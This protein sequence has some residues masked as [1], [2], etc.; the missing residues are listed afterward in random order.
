MSQVIA[1][2]V[3]DCEEHPVPYMTVFVPPISLHY[4]VN[5]CSVNIVRVLS[6]ALDVRVL[7]S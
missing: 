6:S 2:A 3:E 7:S 1:R 5:S 4:A